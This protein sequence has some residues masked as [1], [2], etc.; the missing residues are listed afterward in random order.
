MLRRM[1]FSGIICE[2][3][4]RTF[5]V[6][7]ELFLA[8]LITNPVEMHIHGF[9][10]ALNYCVSE[11]ANSALVVELKWSGALGVAHFGKSC[12]HGNGVFSVDEAGSCFGFLD[13]GHDS[14]DDF[15]VYKNWGVERRRW[16]VRLDW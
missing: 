8:L 2:I 4:L 1:V 14:I 13:G 12:S 10:S 6:D 11:D 15:A 5:P 16:V 3:V 7:V 9:G